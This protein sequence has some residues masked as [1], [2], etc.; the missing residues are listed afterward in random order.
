MRQSI[1][2]FVFLWSNYNKFL[3]SY[4]REYEV[5]LLGIFSQLIFYIIYPLI[6]KYIFDYVVPNK[7]FDQ[8]L[9]YA[10]GISVLLVTCGFG[11]YIQTKYMARVGGRILS[12]LRSQMVSKFHSLSFAFYSG[13]PSNGVDI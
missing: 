5:I 8:L 6:F 4:G 2:D 10:V 13:V 9:A 12:D 3:R 1:A 7:D 11:A